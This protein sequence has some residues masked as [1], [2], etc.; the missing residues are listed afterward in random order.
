MVSCR[1]L[2][3]QDLEF[4]S[5]KKETSGVGCDNFLGF[6][7]QGL[8]RKEIDILMTEPD[9]D[10]TQVGMQNCFSGVWPLVTQI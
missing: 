5:P 1:K 4:S 2:G 9:A 7:V 10:E 3:E 8:R 6:F